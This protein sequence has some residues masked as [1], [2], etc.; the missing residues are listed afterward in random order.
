MSSLISGR[1]GGF[2]IICWCSF[3]FSF[4]S[5]YF[6]PVRSLGQKI[7]VVAGTGLNQMKNYGIKK[8]IGQTAVS[9]N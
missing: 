6:F 7:S 9:G 3:T 8:V 1:F 2:W 5:D 4:V